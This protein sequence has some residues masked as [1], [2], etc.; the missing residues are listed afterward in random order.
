M[1]F[2]DKMIS[3]VKEGSQY[4]NELSKMLKPY[5]DMALI[6]KSKKNIDSR[7]DTENAKL[8][9]YINFL[10]SPD[11]LNSHLPSVDLKEFIIALKSIESSGL[12]NDYK[13]T[14]TK[15]IEEYYPLNFIKLELVVEKYKLVMGNL[16]QFQ[17]ETKKNF[18]LIKFNKETTSHI[19]KDIKK[20]IEKYKEYQSGI[21]FYQDLLE[22]FNKIRDLTSKICYQEFDEKVELICEYNL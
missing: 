5:Q 13:K 18:D 11:F 12:V 10:G 22:Y 14:L 20:V 6:Y 1:D 3:L 17:E 7:T 19:Y 15:G 4:N 8:L 2:I 9:K 16:N 21:F